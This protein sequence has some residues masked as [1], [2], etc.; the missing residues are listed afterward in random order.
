MGRGA[1]ES[2]FKRRRLKMPIF[3]KEGKT[4]LFIHIP[5][6]GGTFVEA[7]FKRNGYAIEF[8]AHGNNSGFLNNVMR[9]SPQHLHLDVLGSL[10][11]FSKFDFI[12]TV[13]RNPLH[14]FES[15]YRMRNPEGKV[16]IDSWGEKIIKRYKKK[17]GCLDNHLR[18]Q[19]EFINS[20]VTWYKLEN[21]LDDAWVTHINDR[22][23]LNLV[24]A[25][26]YPI[27]K[28]PVIDGPPKHKTIS[29]TLRA[30]IVECYQQDF[31]ALNY[32]SSL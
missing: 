26:S 19:V 18:P 24:N 16:P 28:S 32:S 2:V 25:H 12:F 22:F 27:N 11:D 20:Q 30:S 8:L 23:G 1:T 9:I 3:H 6:T 21:K 7:L 17:P 29:E 13:V 31:Q 15:E 5:K 4:I 14:R 10:F